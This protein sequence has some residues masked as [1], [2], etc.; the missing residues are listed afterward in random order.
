MMM[1][2]EGTLMKRCRHTPEQ[3]IRK[4]REAE[5]LLGEGKTIPE[6]AKELQISEQTY[7]RW[8]NQYGGMKAQV[9]PTPDYPPMT[10]GIRLLF[11]RLVRH[12]SFSY[13]VLTPSI[14][15]EIPQ[16][17]MLPSVTR[18]PRLG[19]HR[20]ALGL[21]NAVTIA[22]AVAS[23]PDAVLS[24]HVVTGPAAL[25]VQG[26][27]GI[28]AIQYLYAKELNR[29]PSVTRLVTQRARASLA[30]SSHTQREALVL[31]APAERVHLVLPGVDPPVGSSSLIVERQTDQ[32]TIV[33]VARL[34]DRYKGFD[35]II[36]A[37]PLVRARVPE[38]RWVVVGE[39]SL[40]AE[41]EA[42]AAPRCG[43]LHHVHGQAR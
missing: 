26:L 18:T 3:I 2:E 27:F 17:A 33:M 25:A 29:R 41:L 6:A 32:P 11:E 42:M 35:V 28:P 34:E 14:R 1:G 13:E 23:R 31:G 24:G 4:L 38:V 19:G 21:L 20:S 40:R 5:R 39:G 9:V 16:P 12:S 8:R 36:K 30:I 15:A 10:G 22:R 43:R 7:H 37:L